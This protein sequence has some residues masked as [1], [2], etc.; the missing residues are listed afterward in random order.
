[1]RHSVRGVAFALSISTAILSFGC[2]PP[3][4]PGPYSFTEVYKQVIQP[5]CTNDYCHYAGV[6]LRLSGLDMS[7]Q[8]TAYWNLVG[9][10]AQGA[11]CAGMGFVRVSP[12]DAGASLLYEKVNVPE[13][14]APPCGVQ[15][16]ASQSAISQPGA[17]NI[18]F[19]GIALPQDKISLIEMWIAEGA[20]NN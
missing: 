15:M 17:L 18:E 5:N 19:S 11:P 7:S 2:S 8:N 14:G 16:P 10:P 6:G 9:H 3:P 4:P 13:A 12:D 20:Q 1:M